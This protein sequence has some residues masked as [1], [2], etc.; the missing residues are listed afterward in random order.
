M[1]TQKLLRD[2]NIHRRPPSLELCACWDGGR[3]TLSL[4]G[5]ECSSDDGRC[6]TRERERH[7]V[8]QRC[9]AAIPRVVYGRQAC[10]NRPMATRRSSRLSGRP[11]SRDAA[12]RLAR[13]SGSMT[14]RRRREAAPPGGNASRINTLRIDY[15]IAMPC[16]TF[17]F[18]C[19]AGCAG[20]AQRRCAGRS[21]TMGC[22]CAWA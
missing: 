14:R 20:A 13:R 5:Q 18:L 16:E 10:D 15:S 7:D 8:G 11:L 19:R 9:R 21:A 6:L 1:L 12:Y 17:S 22:S 4:P 2:G 3:P